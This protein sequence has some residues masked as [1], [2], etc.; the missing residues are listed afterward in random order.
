MLDRGSGGARGPAWPGQRRGPQEPALHRPCAHSPAP[1]QTPHPT[2]L[3]KPPKV[4]PPRAG[5]AQ[6]PARDTR[7]TC[8]CLG[9]TPPTRSGTTPQ[10]LLPFKR[11]GLE[12]RPRV[13]EPRAPLRDSSLENEPGSQQ[14]S[15]PNVSS[16]HPTNLVELPKY[17]R[18]AGVCQRPWFPGK[19]ASVPGR[20]A[21]IWA[22]VHTRTVGQTLT[23]LPPA[24]VAL[25][26]LWSLGTTEPGQSPGRGGQGELEEG[27]WGLGHG[28]RGGGG[29]RA[30]TLS[31]SWMAGAAARQGKPGARPGRPIPNSALGGAQTS[32]AG[33]W[34]GA[35]GTL[36]ATVLIP[37]PT[38]GTGPPSSHDARQ[39]GPEGKDARRARLRA[40]R[41]PFREYLVLALAGNQR[42]L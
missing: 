22:A 17:A 28:G 25:A 35:L 42:K 30:L 34:G 21:V 31:P 23:T 19:H 18:H 36:L 4:G 3:Y 9:T 13:P 27:P 33:V 15:E 29:L 14:D 12:D 1:G 10:A 16:S 5:E 32:E 7:G 8:S 39:A 20:G 41:H 6:D 26:T 11:P 38:R 2:R 24:R 40:C 37:C